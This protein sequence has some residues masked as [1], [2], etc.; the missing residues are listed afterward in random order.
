MKMTL[1]LVTTSNDMS[2]YERVGS[3]KWITL[4]DGT[5]CKRMDAEQMMRKLLLCRHTC[6]YLHHSH[7]LPNACALWLLGQMPHL[8]T[9]YAS[10]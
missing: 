3:Y 8:M 9:L 1:D 10:L 5:T 2:A 7:I 4:P 6:T